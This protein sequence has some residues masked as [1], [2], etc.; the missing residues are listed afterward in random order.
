MPRRVRVSAVVAIGLAAAFITWFLTDTSSN[1][2]AQ[3]VGSTGP[4]GPLIG[5]GKTVPVSEQGLRELAG[6]LGQ[7]I[8]WA[9]VKPAMHLELTRENDGR[10]FVRYLPSGTKIGA[11]KPLLTIG[12]YPLNNAYEATRS[13]AAKAGSVKL[14]LPSGVAFY[15]RKTPTSVYLAYRGA[16]VQVEIFDPSAPTARALFAS[17]TVR[18]VPGKSPPAVLSTAPQGLTLGGLQAFAR[19][20]H[21]PMYWI[22]ARSGTTYEVTQTLNGRIFVRYLPVGARVGSK[23]P[24]L[25]VGT[26]PV[27]GAF[28]VVRALASKPGSVRV[29]VPGSGVAFYARSRPTNL[30]EAFPGNDYQ[31]EVYDPSVSEALQL[32]KAARVVAID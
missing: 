13:A 22:G 10:V 4:A 26:Y 18:P 21:H 29:I 2:N 19:K 25:T 23:S 27:R 11:R 12:T 7:P 32:L 14:V 15:S 8:Y 1:R 16:N 9:G 30:Y 5:T 17:G 6:V 24:Y 31:A 20:V 28:N 3:P